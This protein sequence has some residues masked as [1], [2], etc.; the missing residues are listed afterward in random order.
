MIIFK[1]YS[2]IQE[3]KIFQF[4]AF[5]II[6]IL[7]SCFIYH[8]PLKQYKNGKFYDLVSKLKLWQLR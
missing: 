7:M 2:L 6:R 1:L 8:Y 5:I 4:S 3:M